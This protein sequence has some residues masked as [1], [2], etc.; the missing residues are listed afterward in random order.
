MTRTVRL[1]TALVTG[2]ALGVAV[3]LVRLPYDLLKK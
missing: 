2:Y 3:G 1:A